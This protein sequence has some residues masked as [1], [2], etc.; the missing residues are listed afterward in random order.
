MRRVYSVACGEG[1]VEYGLWSVACT[2]GSV[3]G[4]GHVECR[5]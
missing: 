4:A 1:G 3:W 5:I 2:V